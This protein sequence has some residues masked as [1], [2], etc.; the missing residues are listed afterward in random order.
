[1][2]IKVGIVKILANADIGD[3]DNRVWESIADEIPKYEDSQG[4]LCSSRA[5][6]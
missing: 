2:K 4:W 6:G 5:I 3:F 1:M